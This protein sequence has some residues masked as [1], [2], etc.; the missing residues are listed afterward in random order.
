M[1]ATAYVLINLAA[2]ASLV[3]TLRRRPAPKAGEE[4]AAAKP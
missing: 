1:R 2:G 3:A 4:Q